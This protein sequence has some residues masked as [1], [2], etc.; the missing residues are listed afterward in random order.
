MVRAMGIDAGDGTVTVVEIDGNYKKVRLLAVQSTPVADPAQRASAV[1]TAV[2]AARSAGLRGE[3]LLAYPCRE[4]VLRQIELPFQ[5]RDAIRKVV[6]AEIEGEIHSHAVDDMVV[7]FLEI[8][9]TAEKGTRILVASVPKAGLRSHLEAL[10]GSGVEPERVDLDTL[11]LWRAAHW[12]SAFAPAVEGEAAP[13]TALVQLEARTTKV[14]LVEGDKL[15]DMRA[16]RLGDDAV[17][18]DLVRKH[19]LPLATAREAVRACL[20]GGTDCTLEVEAA[21][22][23]AVDAPLAEPGATGAAPTAA[24]RRT[25]VVPYAEVEAAHTAFQQRLARELVRYLAASP[26]ANAI[27]KLLV[28][29]T[30]AEAPGVRELLREVFATEPES[31]DL[32]GKLSHDLDADQVQNLGPGLATALGVALARLGGP[33]GFDLRQEDLA[34]KRGFDR[35]KFPLAMACVLGVLVLLLHSTLLSRQLQNLE[36]ELGRTFLDPKDPKALPQFYG[37]LFSVFRT[38]WFEDG[39]N[40]RIENKG[41]KDYTYRDLVT[42]LQTVPVPKR[43]LVV[44]ERLKKVVEQKQKESGIFEDTSLESGLAV[45]VRFAQVLLPIEPQLGRYLLTKLSLDMGRSRGLEF[46]VALRGEEFRSRASQLEAALEA[47]TKKPD[48]PFLILPGNASKSREHL[49]RPD[50][51][52]VGAY[53]TIKI[54]IKP[55]FEPFGP[56]ARGAVGMLDSIDRLGDRFGG[57]LAAATQTTEVRR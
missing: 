35:V 16:L 33:A 20:R 40:F 34:F 21:L 3:A 46:T 50:S 55:S 1:G 6:K 17:A 8:G 23:V 7:D 5:G 42:E 39:R 51:G 31:L 11:A 19:G 14:L 13:I 12:A 57:L 26:K 37:R 56:S 9:A 38:R 15:I 30:A 45:L 43:L 47:D 49:F 41:G 2:Q 32:L 4:A 53:F 25:V 10:A 22:P 52:V 48:S 54:G 44:R 29:G 28:T 36:Y 27:R 18:E 24:A